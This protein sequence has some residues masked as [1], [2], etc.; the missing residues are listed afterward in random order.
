MTSDEQMT[1][2]VSDAL[3]LIVKKSREK[4]LQQGHKATGEL[5]NSLGGTVEKIN[6]DF[7]GSFWMKKYGIYQ[8]TGIEA[9]RIPFSG[10]G[11]GAKS[12]LYIDALIRWVIQK[13]FESDA[14]KAKGMAFAIAHTHKLKGM[15]TSGGNLDIS[16]RGWLTNTLEENEKQIVEIINKVAGQSMDILLNTIIDKAKK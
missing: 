12:S 16:K 5:I 11:S 1:K 13:G 2:G 10:S 6:A 7:V 4:L 15:H 3:T 14:K 9:S 8:D